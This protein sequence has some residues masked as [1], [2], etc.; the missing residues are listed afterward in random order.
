MGIEASFNDVSQV[1]Q[2]SYLQ[3]AADGNYVISG[4]VLLNL[5]GHSE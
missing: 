5:T 2:A 1:M 4:S 3:M